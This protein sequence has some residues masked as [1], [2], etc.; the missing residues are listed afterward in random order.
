MTFFFFFLSYVC[1]SLFHFFD[2]FA[3]FFLSLDIDFRFLFL[4]DADSIKGVMCPF[5]VP[6][7]KKKV[8]KFFLT[9]E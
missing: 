7:H 6:I 4:R 5:C 8:V 3:V 1:T 2:I 9:L